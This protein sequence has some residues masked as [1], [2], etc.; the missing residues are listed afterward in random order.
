MSGD[1]WL[2]QKT[3]DWKIEE[4]SGLFDGELQWVAKAGCKT[5]SFKGAYHRT[6]LSYSLFYLGGGAGLG[7]KLPDPVKK[8]FDKVDKASEISGQKFNEIASGDSKGMDIL[9]PFSFNDLNGA[10]GVTFSAGVK[11]GLGASGGAV[12]GFNSSGMLFQTCVGGWSVDTAAEFNFMTV[13]IGKFLPNH[14]HHGLKLSERE[15]IQLMYPP[16]GNP[17]L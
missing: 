12:W 1:A 4:G 2:G 17:M 14:K 13:S 3:K 11:A 6:P 5:Y 8:L 9:N 16:R 15:R 7:I 10:G